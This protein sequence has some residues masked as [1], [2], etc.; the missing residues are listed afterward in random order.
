[1]FCKIDH[2]F[3]NVLTVEHHH[4]GGT[5]RVH[6]GTVQRKGP[7]R[8][9]SGSWREISVKRVFARNSGAALTMVTASLISAEVKELSGWGRFSTWKV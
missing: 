3:D 6:G 5:R 4:V 7:H 9:L 2:A 1:M 8:R